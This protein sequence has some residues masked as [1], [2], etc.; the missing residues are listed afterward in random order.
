MPAAG[1]G[2]KILTIAKCLAG[3]F[4]TG[5]FPLLFLDRPIVATHP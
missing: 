3:A 5:V 1:L 2:I 4:R